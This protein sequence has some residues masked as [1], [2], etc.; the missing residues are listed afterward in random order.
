M[1]DLSFVKLNFSSNFNYVQFN[2]INRDIKVPAISSAPH[3]R[4]PNRQCHAFLQGRIQNAVKRLK[5][6]AMRDFKRA[7]PKNVRRKW[8]R[9]P[10][11]I[12]LLQF[13]RT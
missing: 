5:K 12:N 2:Q 8:R 3:I 9:S 4:L 1:I 13:R 7:R 10:K 11:K 6:K